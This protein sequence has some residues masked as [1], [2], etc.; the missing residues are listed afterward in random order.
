MALHNLQ[1][2]ADRAVKER[3]DA[4]EL[5]I[6]A[7]AAAVAGRFCRG[8]VAFQLGHVLTAEQLEDEREERRRELSSAS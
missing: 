4:F 2:R 1:N 6:G 7:L 5:R 3:A 8:N